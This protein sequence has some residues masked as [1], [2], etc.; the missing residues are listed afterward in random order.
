MYTSTRKEHLLRS[1]TTIVMPAHYSLPKHI[2][3]GD[4]GKSYS[5]QQ[6]TQQKPRSPPLDM[7]YC[8]N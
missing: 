2:K 1:I 5:I 4:L 3:P 7:I 6:S 8:K